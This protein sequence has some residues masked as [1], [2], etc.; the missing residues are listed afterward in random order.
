MK[1]SEAAKTRTRATVA[2][3]I[4]PPVDFTKFDALVRQ[5][6]A[7]VDDPAPESKSTIQGDGG[8]YYLFVSRPSTESPNGYLAAYV[9]DAFRSL[10]RIDGLRNKD[11]ADGPLNEDTFAEVLRDILAIEFECPRGPHGRLKAS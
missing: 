2:A 10:C 8:T 1:S 6:K 7:I 3:P 4:K 5:L 9:E 11:L